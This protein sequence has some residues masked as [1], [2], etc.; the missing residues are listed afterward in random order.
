VAGAAFALLGAAMLGCVHLRGTSEQPAIL[1]VRIEGMK[2][3]DEGELVA[4][5]ATHPSD[6]SPPIP[7]AGPLLHQS[8]GLVDRFFRSHKLKV[9]LVDPD[10]LSVDRQRI[11]AYYRERGF[12]DVKVAEAEVVPTGDRQAD[13]VYRVEEGEP[14]QVSAIEISGL[15]AAPEAREALGKLPLVQGD[16]FTVERYDAAR[17]RLVEVLKDTGWAT[18]QVGQEA[19][20]LPEEHR[21]VVRYAVDTGPRYRFGPIFVAGAGSVPRDR[22]R[23]Q[24]GLEL[25]PGDWYDESKLAKAQGRVFEMGVFGGVRVNRGTPDAQRGTIP[26]VV[27]VRE[28]P[29]RTI[30]AGPSVGTQ[31]IVSGGSRADLSGTVGWTHRNFLGDLRRLDLNLRAGYAWLRKPNKS[32]VTALGSAELTQPGA[33]TRNV[34]ASLRL[35]VERGLDPAYDFWSQRLRVSTPIRL[36]RRLTLVPSFSVDVYQLANVVTVVNEADP[37]HP[38]TLQVCKS[39]GGRQVCLLSYLEQRVGW[40]GRDDPLN[41]RRGVYAALAVQEGANLGGYGYRY[42]RFLPDLRA[43]FP[44]GARAVLAARAQWGALVP[45]GETKLPPLVA[46][47]YAGGP[48]SMRGYGVNRLSPMVNF[49]GFVP[50]GGNGLSLYSLELRFPIAGSLLGAV[51]TD[52]AAVSAA[53]TVPSAWKEALAA[54]NLQFASGVGIRYR[55]PFGPLRADLGVRLPS[56]WRAGRFPHVPLGAPT[57]NATQTHEEPLVAFHLTIGEAF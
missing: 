5:L 40:D 50:V 27:A 22:I 21:V 12:Y 18:A 11:E 48:N 7:I 10:Q 39:T 1:N 37:T 42:L 52:A 15:D 38:G 34:D 2:A 53:S 33:L 56:D 8:T 28:A 20:V 25:H 23:E 54:Q 55:T 32:G 46:R 31:G 45:V 26:V 43:Y 3:L 47:F 36:V 9:S 41:P 35:E 49:N 57:E 44:V 29:F 30:R 4:R 19:Q 51:F 24:A 17:A 16:R 6:R 14:V 13:V